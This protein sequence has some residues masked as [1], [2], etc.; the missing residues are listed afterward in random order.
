MPART[1][2]QGRS[3]IESG[4][5]CRVRPRR[6]M[7]LFVAFWCVADAPYIERLIG[8]GRGTDAGVPSAIITLVRRAGC[9]RGIGSRVFGAKDYRFSAF[10]AF[11]FRHRGVQ[12]PGQPTQRYARRGTSNYVNPNRRQYHGPGSCRPLPADP[13]GLRAVWHRLLLR[14][15]KMLWPRPHARAKRR[16]LIWSATSKTALVETSTK[17]ATAEKDWYDGAAP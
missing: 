2:D 10:A 15:W 9:R 4:Q 8:P 16:S 11:P 3:V 14:R 7:G 12:F 1:W 13:E 5:D 17:T 6:T